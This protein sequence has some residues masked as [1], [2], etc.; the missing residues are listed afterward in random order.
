[1]DTPDVISDFSAIVELEVNPFGLKFDHLNS[2]VACKPNN[3]AER[4]R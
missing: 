2:G 1:V 4:G 3:T